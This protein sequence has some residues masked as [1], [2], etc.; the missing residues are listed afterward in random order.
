M[1]IIHTKQ[2]QLMKTLMTTGSINVISHLTFQRPDIHCKLYPNILLRIKL[3]YRKRMASPDK[4]TTQSLVQ[5]THSLKKSKI[6]RRLN[7][8]L[9]KHRHISSI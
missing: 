8:L 4:A 7:T 1:L 3:L 9:T 5:S 2:K 6:Q